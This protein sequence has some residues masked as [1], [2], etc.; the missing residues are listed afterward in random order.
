MLYNDVTIRSFFHIDIQ[1]F[2]SKKTGFN[3]WSE[4][5]NTLFAITLLISNK[6]GWNFTIIL[7]LRP[8]KSE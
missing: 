6:F 8:I 7:S 5:D 3:S 2:H 4:E 1:Y